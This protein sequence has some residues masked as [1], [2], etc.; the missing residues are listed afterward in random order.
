MT[1][2]SPVNSRPAPLPTEITTGDAVNL[3]GSTTDATIEVILFRFTSEAGEEITH[4][5]SVSNSDFRQGAVFFPGQAGTYTLDVFAGPSGQSL[6]HRGNFSPVIVNAGTGPIFLPVDVFS[7]LIL[8]EPLQAELFVGQNPRLVGTLVDTSP[9]QLAIRLDAADGTVGDSEFVSVSNGRFDAPIPI[10]GTGDF[11]IVLFA[12][13]AG[14]SLPFLDSFEPISVLPTQ[15]RVNYE[16]TTLAFPETEVGQTATLTFTFTNVGS[17]TLSI[18]GSSVDSD[19]F[20]VGTLSPT[21]AGQSGTVTV[22]FEPTDVGAVAGTLILTTDD[23]TQP[24]LSLAVSG[25]AAAAPSGQLTLGATALAWPA[26]EVGAESVQA[27]V[28]RNTGGAALGIL[29]ITLPPG[30]TVINALGDATIA[31]GD[32]LEIQI[33]F[34]PLEETTFTGLLT[35]LT[36]TAPDPVTVSLTAIGGTSAGLVGDINGDN[37]VDFTDFLSFAGAFGKSTGD[38][39]FLLLADLDGSGTIDFTDFLTFASQFGKSI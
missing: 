36:D 35:L 38:T 22:T 8:D 7:G 14:E 10:S 4:Q 39:G 9:T 13:Q 20:S 28:L 34:R 31:A 37:A 6:P 29:E 32:S 24:T 17:A 23:P 2:R 12:G 27:L 1:P 33:A 19:Q 18:T 15:P 26:T 21:Q 30:F 5:V 25:T 11:E 16:P 3:T